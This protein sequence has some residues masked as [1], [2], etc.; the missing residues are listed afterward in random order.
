MY[1]G[2]HKRLTSKCQKKLFDEIYYTSYLINL[3]EENKN[4]LNIEFDNLKYFRENQ[5]C[6]TL[7]RFFKE[8]NAN[9]AI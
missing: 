4:D 6:G 1:L 2:K 3:N 8:N 5:T 9:N 7:S